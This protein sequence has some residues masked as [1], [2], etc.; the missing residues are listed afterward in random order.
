MKKKTVAVSEADKLIIGQKAERPLTKQQQIFNRLVK[1][2]EKL[3]R[4]LE[5]TT[6]IL[7]DKLDFYAAHLRPL[8]RETAA[9]RANLAKRLHKFYKSEKRFSA[10][11]REVLREIIGIQLNDVFTFGD[12]APDDELK[13]IFQ[14]VEGIGYEEA[15]A[16]NFAAMKED[17]K[18]TF[19]QAGVEIDLDD[20]HQDLSEE[21]MLRKM[22]EM[23]GEVQEQDRETEPRP[24]RKTKK[25]NEKE[26]REKLVAEAKSKSIA[27]IYK[28]LA[29]VFHPDLELDPTRKIEKESLMK[30]L[31]AAKDNNDLHALLR[32]EVEWIQKEENNLDRLTEEKLEI[33]NEMLKEQAQELDAEIFL[34]MQHPRYE[35]LRRF[36]FSPLE[37]K[38]I[39]LNREKSRMRQQLKELRESL[40][41]LDGD[42]AANE[43]KT[44]IKMFKKGRQREPVSI[45]DLDLDDLF[46]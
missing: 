7:S 1:K 26:Q 20:F 30:Q 3:R 24:R 5:Q 38:H 28:Q 46:R 32:L 6:K 15:A 21:E 9:T 11:D 2:L 8:E 34:T 23:L 12:D 41:K 43:L 40:V 37:L 27:G 39:D 29:R 16:E 10:V 17:M 14:S 44:I 18:Q 36:S 22:M 31:T 33:Y 4:E 42:N 19:A 45:F 35:P 13:E 25:Q